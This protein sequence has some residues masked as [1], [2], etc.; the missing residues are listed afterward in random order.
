MQPLNQLVLFV[1]E[2]DFR[3]TSDAWRVVMEN[4]LSAYHDTLSIIRSD[5]MIVEQLKQ[6]FTPVS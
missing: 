4:D 3:Y 6:E 1:K 2:T 5:M